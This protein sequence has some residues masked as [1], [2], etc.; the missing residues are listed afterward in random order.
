[1]PEQIRFY[2]DPLCPWCYQTSRWAMRL[3]QLG[4]VSI[5]WC[6]FSLSLVN[7]GDEGRADGETWGATALRTVIAVRDA[8]D[9]AVGRFYAA[10]GAARHQR[11]ED[12]NEHAVIE[13]ALREAT[14]DPSLLQR[15]LNDPATWEAVQ[16][17]H[18]V[19]VSAHQ[20]FGVPTIVLDGGAGPSMFG[21]I[22]SAVPD[23]DEARELWRHF[24][25]MVRN[26]NV[27]ELK[28]ER[29]AADLESVRQ[30]ARRRAQEAAT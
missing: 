18:D 1:M 8:G 25:W 23:D 10:I 30:Y 17:E 21:P 2:F 29:L 28:R 20:A 11:G 5:E 24:R 13:A 12:I 14:L 4:E 7:R 9:A 6:V 26:T 27:A 22:I 19:A 15:A 16:R 3:E